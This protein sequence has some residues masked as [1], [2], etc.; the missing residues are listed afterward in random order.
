MITVIDYGCGNLHSLKYALASIGLE[1]QVSRNEAEILDSSGAILPG[2]GAFGAAMENIQ[3]FQLDKTI[4][5]FVASGK[6]LMGI[7]LGM[8][9]LASTSNEFGDHNGLGLI[10]GRVV[11]LETSAVS[12]VPNV[13]WF[14]TQIRDLQPEAKSHIG[15]FYYT[16]SYE[17]QPSDQ[18]FIYATTTH[19]DREISAIVRSDNLIA[20]QFHPEKSGRLGLEF[21]R[22]YF[23]DL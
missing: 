4:H 11:R 5:R 23:C 12:K 17:F 7:C 15:Y 13:G 3:S 10:P 14:P 9:L 21:L 16:H 6:K 1:S 8:H 22:D 19:N 2:V 20:T 18:N